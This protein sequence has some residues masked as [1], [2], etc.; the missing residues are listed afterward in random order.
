MG[1]M[2][3]QLVPFLVHYQGPFGFRR[4]FYGRL[5]KREVIEHL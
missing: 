4:M 2:S 3:M 5:V 1:N